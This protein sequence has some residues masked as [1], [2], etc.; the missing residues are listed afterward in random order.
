MIDDH[1]HQPFAQALSAKF[2]E[3][4]NVPDVSERSLVADH[5]SKTDLPVPLIEAE[6]DRILDRHLRLF[7]S[8]F[9]CPVRFFREEFMDGIK[10]EP[11]FISAYREFAFLDIR[12][13]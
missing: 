7:E 3:Y 2:A 6:A 8:P 9:A 1:P 11:L 12:H 13:V 5:P 4:K 10:I